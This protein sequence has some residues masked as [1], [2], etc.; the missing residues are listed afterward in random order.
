MMEQG[1]D[2]RLVRI[3][4][5]GVHHHACRLVDHDQVIVLEH[6][7]ERNVLRF[8]MQ[9]FGRGQGEREAVPR[10]NLGRTARDDVPADF[11]RPRSYQSLDPFSRQAGSLGQRLVEPSPR[12][13]RSGDDFALGHARAHA[14]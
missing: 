14:R 4:G 2:Q 3:P 5:R 12:C 10:G 7:I 1:V 6:D 11:D 8:R 9:R 13:E